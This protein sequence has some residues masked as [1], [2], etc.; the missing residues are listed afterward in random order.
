MHLKLKSDL[1]VFKVCCQIEQLVLLRYGVLVA[2][3]AYFL[4]NIFIVRVVFA[5]AFL[6]YQPSFWDGS[7]N[8]LGR[9]WDRL[10]QHPIW[11]LTQVRGGGGETTRGG[12]FSSITFLHAY[13]LSLR[14]IAI[15]SRHFF[16]FYI[17]DV[18]R[19][20]ELQATFQ[21]HF[22]QKTLPKKRKT[23]LAN[24]SRRRQTH[25]PMRRRTSPRSSSA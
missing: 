1:L 6:A 25:H 13:H 2:I 12:T 15:H 4:R 10:R 18:G 3:V 14:I 11:T 19:V 20:G 23:Q 16:T 17:Y 5:V 9:P 24:S 22:C 8:R 7:E 21:H